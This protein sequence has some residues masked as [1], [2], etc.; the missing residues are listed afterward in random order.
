[1]S[2][3]NSG[4]NERKQSSAMT[5]KNLIIIGIAASVVILFSI[6]AGFFNRSIDKT[7][8]TKKADRE[9]LSKAVS[10]VKAEDSG[11]NPVYNENKGENKSEAENKSEK[12]A[13]DKEEQANIPKEEPEKTDTAPEGGMT[14]PV[15]GEIIKE[16]SGDELVYSQ[17]MNDWRTHNGIDFAAKEGEDVVAVADGTVEAITDGIM[18][19]CIIILHG[20]SLRTIYANLAEGAEVKVGDNI[21]AGTVIGKVGNT[22]SAESAEPSHLHFEISVNQETTDPAKYLLSSGTA[23]TE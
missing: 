4:R 19:R 10:E 13:E 2:T 9:A 15:K 5:R 20:G 8:E 6:T 7:E 12:P 17:T 11:L 1:M 21:T 3:K 14:P 18:G 23:E 22:A 16:Y